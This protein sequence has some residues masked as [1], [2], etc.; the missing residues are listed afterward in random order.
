MKFKRTK[1]YFVDCAS[2]RLDSKIKTINI[3]RK[4]RFSR[5]HFWYTGEKKS[6]NKKYK[7]LTN[8]E[9]SPSNAPLISLIRRGKVTSRNPHLYTFNSLEDV[10]NNCKLDEE[11]SISGLNN[12]EKR[13]YLNRNL[14]FNSFDEICFGNSREHWG[15]QSFLSSVIILDLLFESYDENLWRI[16]LGY[17][18]LNIEFE[19]IRLDVVDIK[20]V[21]NIL[22][23]E[24]FDLFMTGIFRATEVALDIN[25]TFWKYYE[26][27][28][29][30]ES[31][32]NKM[33]FIDDLLNAYYGK[34]LKKQIDKYIDDISYY[35]YKGK[36]VQENSTYQ[37][38]ESIIS[39]QQEMRLYQKG[40]TS[41][42]IIQKYGNKVWYNDLINSPNRD[43]FL[44][45]LREYEDEYIEFEDMYAIL[46]TDILV[47]TEK[48]LDSLSRLQ[49]F[50]EEN[51]HWQG[52]YLGYVKKY[53][54]G[55]EILRYVKTCDREVLR[56]LINDY[57]GNRN[58]IGARLRYF[59]K[60][61]PYSFVARDDSV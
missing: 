4:T 50:R 47:L 20:K 18:P 45:L 60:K 28:E 52:N 31:N 12:L 1:Q 16:V 11:G 24:H 58:Y 19:K 6:K 33:S 7:K 27:Y 13:N 34:V 25:H 49:S 14:M 21:Y 10:L 17:M 61:H 57:T 43:S 59:I 37:N 30:N 32:I 54:F 22:F 15:L 56:P 2:L 53:Q 42:E 3:E 51:K 39:I 36:Y 8:N 38:L 9:I 29:K 35:G 46:A 44:K 48:L 55:N 41:N 26:E 5:E 40:D 23:R